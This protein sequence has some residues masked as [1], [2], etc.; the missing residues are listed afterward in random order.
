MNRHK[1][2]RVGDELMAM[3]VED[4]LKGCSIC[5][6]CTARSNCDI[7][8]KSTTIS[9]MGAVAPIV[10]CSMFDEDKPSVNKR[11]FSDLI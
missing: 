9:K 1:W 5:D 4:H 7:L 2:V 3:P 8:S 10:A 6:N 11:L